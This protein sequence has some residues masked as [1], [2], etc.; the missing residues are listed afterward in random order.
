M[1]SYQDIDVRLAE[2]EARL[3]FLFSTMKGKT[4]RHTGMFHP[5]G[6]PII[7]QKD[8]TMEDVYQ[9]SKTTEIQDGRDA[10]KASEA[11]N[12]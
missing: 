6:K 11:S 5:D 8:V 3:R 12:G 4:V 2:V 9:L 1:S 7:E 10:L